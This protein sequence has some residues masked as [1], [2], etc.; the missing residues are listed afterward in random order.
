ME[1]RTN[2][3]LASLFFCAISDFQILMQFHVCHWHGRVDSCYM[4]AKQMHLCLL[5]VLPLVTHM[6]FFFKGEYKDF[7]DKGFLSA[8]WESFFFL[9]LRTVRIINFVVGDIPAL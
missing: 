3:S 8:F 1:A 4:M 6:G 2:L 7:K 5:A 9:V